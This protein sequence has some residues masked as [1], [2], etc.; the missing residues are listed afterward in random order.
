M[1]HLIIGFLLTIQA[2]IANNPLP[3]KEEQ[4]RVN[5]DVMAIEIIDVVN[6]YYR[7]KYEVQSI[8]QD[9]LGLGA[10]HT[11]SEIDKVLSS[12]SE[13]LKIGNFVERKYKIFDKICNFETLPDIEYESYLSNVANTMRVYKKFADEHK[14]ELQEMRERVI[15]REKKE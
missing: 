8:E 13:N 14:Q 1:K 9:V 3:D 6:S 10:K 12:I 7:H 2:A 15:K 11:I 5:Y 4:C